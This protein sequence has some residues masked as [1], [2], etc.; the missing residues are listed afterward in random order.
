MSN[1]IMA[2]KAAGLSQRRAA[3]ESGI[4]YR[5][6]QNWELGGLDGAAFGKV[7]RLAKLYGVS[8]DYIAGGEDAKA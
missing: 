7:A 3:Q 1:L 8:L 4:P 2:R 6:I 5:T